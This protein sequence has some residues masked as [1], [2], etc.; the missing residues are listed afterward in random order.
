MDQLGFF[1]SFLSMQKRCG[2]PIIAP[3]SFFDAANW[4]KNNRTEAV[5]TEWTEYY[6]YDIP[7]ETDLDKIHPVVF[8]EEI[9]YQLE[10][11]EGSA[12]GAAV[13]LHRESCALLVDWLAEQIDQ[14]K[15]EGYPIQ[16][17]M[18]LGE[19]P[20][21]NEACEKCGIRSIHFEW[22]SLRPP[23]YPR[24]AYFDALG[25]IAPS[26]IEKNYRAFEQVKDKLPILDRKSLLA[27]M[28]RNEYCSCIQYLGREP[29]YEVGICGQEEGLFRNL[30][31]NHITNEDLL[32][33]VLRSYDQKEILFRAHPTAPLAGATANIEKDHSLTSAQF[34]S[35]CKRIVSINSNM[36]FD[37]MLWGRTSCV[38]GEMPYKFMAETDV[39]K[40]V[41]H[42]VDAAF[43]NFVVFVFFV[44]YEKLL[45]AEYLNWRFSDP[46]IEEIYTTHLKYY[47]AIQ[48]LDYGKI[49]A[50]NFSFREILRQ[51]G[52]D[53]SGA[54]LGDSALDAAS[55]GLRAKKLEL[56]Q[57]QTS[58]R[59]LFD[60][61]KEGNFS[62]RLQVT[63]GSKVQ[64]NF[65]AASS[66]RLSIRKAELDGQAVVLVP[67]NAERDGVS[68]L[69]Q[70]PSFSVD[71]P[72]KGSSAD[73]YVE[74]SLV[75]I[76]TLSLME[77]TARCSQKQNE[78]LAAVLNEKESQWQEAKAYIATLETAAK[79]KEQ[80][81]QKLEADIQ[82]L[83]GYI[84]KLEIEKAQLQQEKARSEQEK[85]HLE[86][87]K[88]D[89]QQ[90][91]AQLAAE[92]LRLETEKTQV[93]AEKMQVETEKQQLE[94]S[95]DYLRQQTA[96]DPLKMCWKIIT[97]K[98]I[99]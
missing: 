39:S 74:G 27:L 84:P 11:Q 29:E 51:K 21:V 18:V 83:S 53:E 31:R 47:C 9:L 81:Q 76:P 80:W 45:D 15:K 44:P 42:C 73:L 92:K 13:A 4:T 60:L 12:S 8:P 14:L 22:S 91:Q 48:Q 69:T 85:T 97:K 54:S 61:D 57:G 33:Q 62:F 50:S 19:L 99:I 86:Q 63:G 20:S 36:A 67:L 94:A 55:G 32:G 25:V 17:V 6:C 75:E 78:E 38:I 93:T 30:A 72:E 43:L 58:R 23:V 40:K 71:I 7:K 16:A 59:K 35:R 70:M 37:A 95:I 5:S 26:E 68:F 3:A 41:E 79:E 28:L 64:L 49:S 34:I 65:F 66:C 98:P 88:A 2:G 90:Q 96:K 82:E 24:L 87:E 52:C 46:S 1:F 77:E 56:L 89:L 10:K